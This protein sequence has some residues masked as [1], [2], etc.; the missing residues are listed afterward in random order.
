MFR[1][2][3]QMYNDYKGHVKF[4]SDNLV[5]GRFSTPERQYRGVQQDLGGLL[6]LWGDH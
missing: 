2:D 6:C 1:F 5:S 3:A 4:Y